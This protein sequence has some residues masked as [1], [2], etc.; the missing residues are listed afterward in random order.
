M[1][2]YNLGGVIVCFTLNQWRMIQKDIC[3]VD[4]AKVKG[5]RNAAGKTIYFLPWQWELIMKEVK[6]AKKAKV[7]RIAALV[8]KIAMFVN[9]IYNEIKYRPGGA[10]A[11]QAAAEF[12]GCVS[13]Q[14]TK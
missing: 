3:K 1:V 6:E 14:S 11:V 5:T 13:Q 4:W 10:G 8:G 7:R 9:M 2:V 12:E